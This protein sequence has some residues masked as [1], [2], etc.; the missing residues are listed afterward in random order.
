MN[1]A[2]RKNVS[3]QE[4]YQMFLEFKTYR[5]AK[6]PKTKTGFLVHQRYPNFSCPTILSHSDN[7]SCVESD[8]REDLFDSSLNTINVSIN[9]ELPM[10]FS[11]G[12]KEE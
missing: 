8:S 11:Y 5:D 9:T 12:P 6:D 3:E 1:E 10:D 2:T 4:K 7:D